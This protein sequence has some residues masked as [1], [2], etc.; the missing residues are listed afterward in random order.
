MRCHVSLRA[1]DHLDNAVA[2]SDGGQLESTRAR[3]LDGT[4]KAFRKTFLQDIR[5]NHIPSY[6]IMLKISNSSLDMCYISIYIQGT[7]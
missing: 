3:L 1:K 2:K 7:S 5:Q 6:P 4:R